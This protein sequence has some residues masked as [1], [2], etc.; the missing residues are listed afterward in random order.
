M[1]AFLAGT[2]ARVFAHNTFVPANTA[3]TLLD[4]NPVTRYAFKSSAC[5]DRLYSIDH[6]AR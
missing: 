1:S 5:G 4:T 3:A 6:L 2:V